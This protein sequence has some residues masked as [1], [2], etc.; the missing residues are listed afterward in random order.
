MITKWEAEHFDEFHHATYTQNKGKECMRVRRNGATQT[1]KRKANAERFRVPVVHGLRG[2]SQIT[3]HNAS[4]WHVAGMC[5][6]CHSFTYR[7]V[8]FW[9]G[10]QADEYLHML[11]EQTPGDIHWRW[12]TEDG[13]ERLFTEMSNALQC[14]D[15]A[16]DTTDTYP[17]IGA[18]YTSGQGNMLVTYSIGYTWLALHEVIPEFTGL[19]ES[20]KIRP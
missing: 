1:W 13:Q 19:Q 9:Q 7:Q 14:F 4:E 18:D 16:A 10:D 17:G 8:Y 11:Y 5:P 12:P 3:E 2:Y 15:T 6:R 20:K